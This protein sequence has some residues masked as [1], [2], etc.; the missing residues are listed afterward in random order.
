MSPCYSVCDRRSNMNIFW[1]LVIRETCLEN[2]KFTACADDIQN[3]EL[4]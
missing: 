3:E 1:A 2:I 4:Y